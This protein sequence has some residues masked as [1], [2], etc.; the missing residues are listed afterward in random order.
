MIKLKNLTNCVIVIDLV[1]I[2]C[3]NCKV[4]ILKGIRKMK[5]SLPKK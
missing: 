5:S 3:Y 1:I 4:N 2:K